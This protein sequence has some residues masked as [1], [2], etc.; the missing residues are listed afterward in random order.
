M[1]C[2]LYSI[3]TSMLYRPLISVTTG[4]IDQRRGVA[5]GITGDRDFDALE[6]KPWKWKA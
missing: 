3:R 5:V 4:Y 6:K 1:Q 2:I